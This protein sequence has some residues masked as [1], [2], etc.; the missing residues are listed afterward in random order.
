MKT[1]F[2]ISQ[3]ATMIASALQEGELTEELEQALVIN[4]TELQEKAIN[5]AYAIKSI[6]SDM[7]IISEE[8]ARLQAL[9]KAKTEAVDR[10]KNA[11]ID[12]M[13]IYGIEKVTSPTLT[14]SIRRSE[15]VEVANDAL[16]DPNYVSKKIT[17]TPNKIA[18]K[19][20]IKNGEAV[21]GAVIRENYSLQIK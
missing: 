4:Q 1:L 18:I 2:N 13:Q 15:A 12:A 5:Y 17:F 21:E 6:E 8:I 16:L 14:L 10:M 7:D 11:V 19:N 9:K 20:A 3:E